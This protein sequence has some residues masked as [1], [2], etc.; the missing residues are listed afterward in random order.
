MWSLSKALEEI[1]INLGDPT[2]VYSNAMEEVKACMDLLAAKNDQ[3]IPLLSNFTQWFSANQIMP[4]LGV[5]FLK[6]IFICFDHKYPNYTL[7]ALSTA[8]AELRGS[9]NP[10]PAD[11]AGQN[12]KKLIDLVSLAMYQ[13]DQRVHLAYHI[14][15]HAYEM[16]H[17]VAYLAQK[18]RMPQAF[19]LIL[20]LCGLFHDAIFLRN[21][22]QDEQQSAALLLSV[23]EPFLDT[24]NSEEAALFSAFVKTMIV[25]GTLPIFLNNKSGQMQMQPFWEIYELLYP[26]DAKGL[27]T[28]LTGCQSMGHADVQRSLT[29]ELIKDFPKS[30][31]S[32]V[33]FSALNP[34]VKSFCG[35]LTGLVVSKADCTSLAMI[36]LGQSIRT[37]SELKDS[38]QVC[39]PLADF[40][41]K[42]RHYLRGGDWVEFSPEELVNI[43]NALI[44]EVNFA[45]MNRLAFAEGDVVGAPVAAPSRRASVVGTPIFS[46]ITESWD[47]HKD[48]FSQ[49]QNALLSNSEAAAGAGGEGVAPNQLLRDLLDNAKAQQGAQVDFSKVVDRTL[50]LVQSEAVDAAAG[51][52]AGSGCGT[53]TGL[54]LQLEASAPVAASP[55]VAASAPV[56]ASPAVAASASPDAFFTA[57]SGSSGAAGGAVPQAE[58][59]FSCFAVVHRVFCGCFLGGDKV[60]PFDHSAS[61][62]SS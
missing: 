61:G 9:F 38:G 49:I 35:G 3:L 31:C 8:D 43:S 19:S 55:A 41:L 37:F 48:L 10:G 53:G 28:V 36:K 16:M 25:A 39:E 22:V 13:C 18:S 30:D 58:G 50:R 5:S 32:G 29:V 59:R 2:G 15:P 33:N 44:C 17:D 52:G 11:V 47:W 24:L 4:R 51:A 56:A 60:V 62:P 40:K 23:L 42:M 14:P 46:C 45:K 57:F 27:I 1:G 34:I 7:G 20:S 12:F 54:S 6:E 21:R 26:T